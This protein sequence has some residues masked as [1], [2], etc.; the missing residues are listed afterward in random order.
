MK[1]AW[2]GGGGTGGDRESTLTLFGSCREM[3]YSLTLLFLSLLLLVLLL[4][5]LLL[6]PLRRMMLASGGGGLF[7]SGL[8]A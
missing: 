5:L 2:L 6:L 7:L 4:L 1:D 8:L 3:E